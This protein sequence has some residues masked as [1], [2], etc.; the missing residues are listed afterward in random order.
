[1]E[2][3]HLFIFG[4]VK[5]NDSAKGKLAQNKKSKQLIV[6]CSKGSLIS[7][8]G[9]ILL[10]AAWSNIWLIIQFTVVRMPGWGGY[11]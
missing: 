8:L 9:S 7:I 6:Q 5:R 2:H 4:Y 1:M 10:K 11:N 3:K